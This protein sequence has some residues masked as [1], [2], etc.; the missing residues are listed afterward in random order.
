MVAN[1][2]DQFSDQLFFLFI[3]VTILVTNNFLLYAL[4]STLVT[5]VTNNFWFL[6]LVTNEAFSCSAITISHGSFT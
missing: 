5:I 1:F 4:V 2:K 6:K 3:I